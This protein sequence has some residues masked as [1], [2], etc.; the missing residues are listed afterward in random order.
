[1]A[2]KIVRGYWNCSYCGTKKID[3][4]K[5]ECP[6]CAKRKPEGTKYYIGENPSRDV[7][8]KE[9]LRKAGISESEC[10]GKHKEWVC[11]YCNQLNNYSD[12]VCVACGATK[13]ERSGE[14]GDPSKKEKAISDLITGKSISSTIDQTYSQ[15]DDLEDYTN[16]SFINGFIK[17]IPAAGILLGI[18]LI[19][20][21]FWPQQ[22]KYS[23]TGFEWSRNIAIE[24]YKTFEE[25]G[26]ILPSDARLIEQKEEFYG[27][28]SVLDHYET[29]TKEKSREVFDHYEEY[30][31]YIDNGN[32][33][34]TENTYQTPVYR[35]EYYTETYEDPV[36]RDEPVYKTKYYYEIDRWICVDNYS[37]SGTDKNPYWNKDYT[38][39]EKQRDTSKRE[40][41]FVV[42]SGE[43]KNY[44][45]SVNYDQWIDT[46][47]GD[48]VMVTKCRI[49]IVYKKEAIE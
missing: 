13:K 15:G 5:D 1:M 2:G 25:S 47:Y 27:Y 40:Q 3:G 31:S 4:L 39:L 6:N 24:E 29:K 18:L 14:Y 7:V 49:G 22:K 46:E 34:F 43:E 23:V 26:W 11:S 20:F 41:Y 8:T 37:S 35:T 44:K 21:M 17:L 38:L 28:T 12:Q 16:P 42:Y 48:E 10:D 45:E 32:G 30:T 36:Y 9:E 19:L 33:T